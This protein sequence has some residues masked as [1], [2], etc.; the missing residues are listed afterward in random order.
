[1]CRSRLREAQVDADGRCP[2]RTLSSCQ[3]GS[4]SLLDTLQWP[5]RGRRWTCPALP[6]S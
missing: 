1:M 2:P 5:G 6:R 3:L 4:D